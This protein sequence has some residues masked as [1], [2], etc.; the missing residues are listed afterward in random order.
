MKI[1]GIDLGTSNSLVSYFDGKE[2]KIIRNVLNEELTPSVVGINDNGEIIV[3]KIAKERLFTNPDKTVSVFKRFMG[4]K[5]E[6]YLG[7]KKFTPIDLSAFLLKEL[8]EDAERYLGEECTEAIIS[9]PAYFNNSQ[10]EATITAAKIAGLKVERLISEPTAAALSYGLNEKEEGTFMVLD[11]GGGTFDVSILEMFEGVMQVIAINGDNF[12]GGEDFTKAIMDDFLNEEGLE[13]N[14]L[15]MEEVT[16]LYYLSERCKI[17]LCNGNLGN[18]KVNLRGNVREYNITEGKFNN[19]ASSLMN[20]ISIPI[21]RALNDSKIKYDELDAVVLIGGATRMPIFKNYIAKLLKTFPFNNIDPDKTVCL[22]S[23]IQG[24]LKN[25]AS[26]L[27]E[28]VFTDVCPYTL[29]IEILD[30]NTGKS[31]FS[32]IIERNKSIPISRV[33]TY[34]TVTAGQRNVSIKVYQGENLNVEENLYLGEL[35]VKLPK[36]D[37]IQLIFIR[38]TYDKNGILE[39]VATNENKNVKEKLILKNTPGSLSDEE[40]NKTIEIFDKIKMHPRENIEYSYLITR[41]ERIYSQALGEMRNF[42]SEKLSEYEV[43]LDKQDQDDILE[44][45]N[46]FRELLDIIEE[47]L[48]I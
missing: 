46:N 18:M 39:V 33:E 16:Y 21:L 12:L 19:I 5:K 34:N 2:P 4:T 20:R 31:K 42:I 23:C 38:F 36:N 15:T 30:T 17:E 41:A 32:P 28:I 8:K 24:A 25:K 22:G 35:S 10:R 1:L 27:E 14:D 48:Y 29:G 26:A 9:V 44:A 6:Y 43:I 13:F 40:L 11:L 37:E 7:N 3:G 45:S 47:E